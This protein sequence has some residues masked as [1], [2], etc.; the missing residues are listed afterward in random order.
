LIQCS[1]ILS[2]LTSSSSFYQSKSK[3][4]QIAI[5]PDSMLRWRKIFVT[6]LDSLIKKIYFK[7]KTILFLKKSTNFNYIVTSKVIF[8][9][10]KSNLKFNP[11][12][13]LQ[14][15]KV[16]NI[17][18]IFFLLTWMFLLTCAYLTNFM[19]LKINDHVNL[20]VLD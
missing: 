10:M 3:I 20:R 11:S 8:F 17:Y 19:G 5:K 18:T 1:N 15:Y 14:H 4:K 7:T 16:L 9:L 2:S 6:K 12:Q 13:P